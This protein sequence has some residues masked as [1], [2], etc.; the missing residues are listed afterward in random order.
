MLPS[1]LYSVFLYVREVYA[2]SSVLLTLIRHRHHTV[3]ECDG[4][5]GDNSPVWASP[6]TGSALRVKRGERST[7]NDSSVYSLFSFLRLF[8]DGADTIFFIQFIPIL[9]LS[10]QVLF[11]EFTGSRIAYV[12]EKR[13]SH[14][15]RFYKSSG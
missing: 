2:V 4:F 5:C 8:I 10:H 1:A 14:N 11:A 9:L 6:G 3:C 15:F 13:R 12:R 7:G